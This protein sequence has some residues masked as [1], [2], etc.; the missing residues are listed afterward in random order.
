MSV[1]EYT[2]FGTG[3]NDRH[4]L[5][6]EQKRRL[7]LGGGVRRH[8]VGPF[9]NEDPASVG[10]DLE[11][12]VQPVDNSRGFTVSVR[13]FGRGV[14][15]DVGLSAISFDVFLTVAGTFRH[16]EKIEVKSI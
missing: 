6:P 15:N 7:D 5:V 8:P 2:I 4:V 1:E 11:G 14:D 9:L 16:P 13:G 12:L 10:G 3:S